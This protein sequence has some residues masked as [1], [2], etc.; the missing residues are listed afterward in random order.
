MIG[1]IYFI[2]F[3]HQVHDPPERRLYLQ[4]S[5]PIDK[6]CKFLVQPKSSRCLRIA[7]FIPYHK[8]LTTPTKTFHKYI[9]IG[10]IEKLMDIDMDNMIS[11]ITSTD[12]ETKLLIYQI[13]HNL[14]KN[15]IDEYK[16]KCS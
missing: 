3:H 4:I 8:T 10:N 2:V 14:F 5:N 9:K 7:K 1:D 15:I 12:E 13:I 16:I 6:K 11:M